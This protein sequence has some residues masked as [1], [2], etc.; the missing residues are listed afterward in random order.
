MGFG[1]HSYRDMEFYSYVLEG[2]PA[3]K[4]SIG[5]SSSIKPGDEQLMSAGSRNHAQ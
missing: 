1:S 3:H 4:D 2:E 5:N